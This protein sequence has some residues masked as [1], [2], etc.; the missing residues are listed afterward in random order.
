MQETSEARYETGNVICDA[1][2]YIGD[3]AYAVLPEDWAHDL[4]EMEKNFWSGLG[5]LVDKQ[6]KWIDERIEASDRLRQQWRRR[7]QP[8]ESSGSGI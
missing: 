8:P 1:V 6:L 7:T 3:A 4:A 5:C 2:R